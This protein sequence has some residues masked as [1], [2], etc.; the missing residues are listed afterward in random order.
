MATLLGREGSLRYYKL[1][2][3]SAHLMALLFGWMYQ[4]PT[5]LK[6]LKVNEGTQE[7]LLDPHVMP[8]KRL[9]ILYLDYHVF[10][11]PTLLEAR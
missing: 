2:L 3:C 7:R 8:F 9:L 5:Q 10:Q 6:A 11:R 1:L 4:R